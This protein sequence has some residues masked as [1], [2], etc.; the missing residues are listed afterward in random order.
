MLILKDYQQRALTALKDYFEECA[1]T[2]D[3]DTAFYSITKQSYGRGIPYN[4]V[5]ELPG[6][7]YACI[8]IPTGGGKTLVASY[9][10]GLAARDLLHSDSTVVL[11]LVPLNAIRT[12]TLDALQDR[13]HPYR[14]A[15]EASASA[16]NVLDVEQALNVKK[17]DLDAGVT[18][19]VS[20]MQAFKVD[21]TTGRKVY[22]DSGYLMDHFSG[23]PEELKAGLDKG[24]G[25]NIYNSL[26]NVLHV[27]RPVVIVDEAHNA[28][29]GLTF[30]TLAR[31]NPSCIIEF[32]ATPDLKVNPSN[33]LHTVSAKELQAEGMI[34]MPIRLET[35]PDW[36]ELLADAVACRDRLEK[37]A[38]LER[39][40]THEYIRPILLIQAQPHSKTRETISVEEVVE[41][42]ETDFSIPRD[43]IAEA[44]G[45]KKELDDI[46]D[47]AADDCPIRFIVTMQ[48]L[49]EGWDCPF[50]YVLCSVAEMTSS[51]YVEQILGR[52]MRL[53]RAAWKEHEDL[54]KAYAF[55]AS[56]HFA[57]AANSLTDALVQNGFERQE[58]KDLIV[59]GLNY[60]TEI[61]I[62]E[63]QAAVGT[64][65]V[66]IPETPSVESLSSDLRAKV[67]ID[68][69]RKTL[70]VTTP[71]TA[72]EREELKAVFKTDEGKAAVDTAHRAAKALPLEDRGTPSERGLD[73]SV[74]VLAI[75]QGKLFEQ[76]EETHFLDHPWR[77]SE[78]DAVLSEVEY[79]LESRDAE[80]GEIAIDEK[81]GLSARF[82]DRLH[83]QMAL[84]VSGL[85]WTV[86]DLVY[87]LDRK[88]RHPDI[89][90]RETGLYLLKLVQALVDQRSLPLERLVHD[91]FRLMRS[92]EKKINGHRQGAR[93]KA[94]QLALDPASKTPL[95]VSPDICFQYD[96]RQY[97]AGRLYRGKFKFQKHYYPDIEDMNGE[98]VECAQLI[99]GMDEVEY[100]VRNIERRPNHSFWLQT[101]TDRFYPD[102]VAKLKDGRILV[103]E[104]KGADRWSN[105]D[106]KEKRN[107]GELWAKRSDG[108]CLFVMP[109]GKDFGAITSLVRKKVPKKR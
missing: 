9:T 64:A 5:K 90:P 74:P 57:E 55:A 48:A 59:P 51:T 24:E 92:I 80:H 41:A 44:T 11:W 70:T 32:T 63:D 43:Q 54:N 12:Q 58:A 50:A 87:W 95:V 22:R 67:A 39:Q 56:R 17:A 15:L 3:A 99:D 6:L 60:Q 20:T 38:G 33:V 37:I 79:S 101:S 36:K 35:R 49:R 53:P 45:A 66:D 86:P 97:P 77:L 2:N 93:D 7:P 69:T 42:L 4:P 25:G 78:C 18:I 104:Y 102:F 109:K 84:F 76:F 91:K 94:Y 28:R 1:K 83:G 96:P 81:G 65:T 52:I 14:Q 88:I 34:K 31:F 105:D 71:L 40:K 100:W 47:I 61:D 26:A 98:E 30:E 73:F 27:R 62:N 85:G 82:F 107:I 8:R 19:I 89:E 103:V 23:L 68:E 21:D 29:T 46:D 16:V 106:S 10:V 108:S 72:D 75:K 13:D